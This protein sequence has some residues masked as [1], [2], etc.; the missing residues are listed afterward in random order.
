MT[1]QVFTVEHI[2]DEQGP[3]QRLRQDNSRKGNAFTGKKGY[4]GT[5]ERT[6]PGRR[7]QDNFRKKNTTAGCV[8]NKWSKGKGPT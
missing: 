3:V 7:R 1:K 6:P 4:L 8:V 2:R 5:K